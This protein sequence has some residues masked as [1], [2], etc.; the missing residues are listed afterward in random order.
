MKIAEI[1]GRLEEEEEFRLFPVGRVDIHSYLTIRTDDIQDEEV[2]D[3]TCPLIETTGE[4]VQKIKDRN[5]RA[6]WKSMLG[7]LNVRRKD[8]TDKAIPVGQVLQ[9]PSGKFWYRSKEQPYVHFELFTDKK[10]GGQFQRKQERINADSDLDT[11]RRNRNPGR[12]KP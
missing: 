12:R 10:R 1:E 7:G 8:V 2:H 5:V 11:R 3:L 6:N 9:Q 4:D